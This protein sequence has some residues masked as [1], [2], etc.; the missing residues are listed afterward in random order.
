MLGLGETN[1]EILSVCADLREA[2]CDFFTL[3]Q[4]LAPSRIHH[5]VARYVCPEEFAMVRGKILKLRFRHVEAGPLVRSSY[6]A[7]FQPL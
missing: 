5:P 2:G 7:E 1:R 3:G 4:Y 6:H